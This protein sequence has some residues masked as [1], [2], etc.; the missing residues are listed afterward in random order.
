MQKRDSMG[1]SYTPESLIQLYSSKIHLSAK[2]EKITK[3]PLKKHG[4]NL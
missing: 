2:S 4:L 3:G 1:V